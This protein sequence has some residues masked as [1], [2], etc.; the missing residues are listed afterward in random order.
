MMIKEQK[1]QISKLT[2]SLKNPKS[3]QVVYL[4]KQVKNLMKDV[5]QRNQTPE[6]SKPEAAKQTAELTTLKE[7]MAK[8]KPG[9]P[10]Q[11]G[12]PET[13]GVVDSLWKEKRPSR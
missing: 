8:A 11:F 13:N 9:T 7:Q 6:S 2:A 3:D 12:R 5:L 1:R 10:F 4:E